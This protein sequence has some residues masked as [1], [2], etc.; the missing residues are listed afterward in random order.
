LKNEKIHIHAVPESVIKCLLNFKPKDFK[1]LLSDRMVKKIGTDESYDK[2]VKLLRD[3]DTICKFV[4]DYQKLW[5]QQ[6]NNNNNIINSSEH[7][8]D[9]PIYSPFSYFKYAV[10]SHISPSEDGSVERINDSL[11]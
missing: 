8:A 9:E 2:E 5:K 6:V 1:T 11:K 7:N 4:K 10:N 3:F